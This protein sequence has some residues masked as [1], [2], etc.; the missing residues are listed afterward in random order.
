MA[1]A[2]SGRLSRAICASAE[3]LLAALKAKPAVA[4]IMDRR[5]SPKRVSVEDEDLNAKGKTPVGG[6]LQWGGR[7]SAGPD[8]VMQAINVSIGFDRKL[9]REDITG[10]R[11]HAAMLSQCGIISAMDAEAI[12]GGLAAIAAEIESHTFDFADAL[13]DIHTNI[14]LA[15]KSARRRGAYIPGA[16]ATTRWRRISG[17]GC[18]ARSSICWRRSKI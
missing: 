12:D 16:A 3:L 17:C 18:V 6:S 10:S 15:K 8:A 9:W 13:E 14:D 1:E 7:F 5:E 4:A 2:A 11:A